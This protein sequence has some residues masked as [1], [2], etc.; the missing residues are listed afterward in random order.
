[1]LQITHERRC[2]IAMFDATNLLISMYNEV[3][4]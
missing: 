4:T 2:G 1:M 3:E